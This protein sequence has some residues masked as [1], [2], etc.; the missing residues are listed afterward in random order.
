MDESHPPSLFTVYFFLVSCNHHPNGL[1]VGRAFPDTLHSSVF[2]PTKSNLCS[3]LFPTVEYKS[4]L[5]ATWSWQQ[6]RTDAVTNHR[7]KLQSRSSRVHSVVHTVRG[8]S[9][10]KLIR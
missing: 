5:K 9:T 2:V 4:L 1:P 6:A 10:S 8:R 3:W 7:S